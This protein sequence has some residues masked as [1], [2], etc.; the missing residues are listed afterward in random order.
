MHQANE[1]RRYNETS[2]LIGWA[3]AQNDPCNGFNCL[4]IL[5]LLSTHEPS[6]MI[7]DN[8]NNA[9]DSPWDMKDRNEKYVNFDITQ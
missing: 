3:H 7:A 5:I 4:I 6:F 1:R 9:D 8:S 2:S